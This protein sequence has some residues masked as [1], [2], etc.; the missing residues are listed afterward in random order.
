MKITSEI[1]RHLG[2]APADKKTAPKLHF[3]DYFK[4]GLPTPPASFGHET[5]IGSTGWGMLGNDTLGDCVCAG[6]CHETMLYTAEGSGTAAIFAN[7]QAI[8]LYSAITGY[9]PKKP[10]SDNGTSMSAAAA[11]RHKSGIKDASGAIHKIG[12]YLALTKGNLAEHLC[13][14]YLFGAVGVGIEFPAFA[15]TQFNDGQPW[16]VSKK[17][18]AIEGGHY[19]PLV[20]NRANLEVVTWG[21]LQGMTVAFFEKYNDESIVYLSPEILSG[22]GVTPEGFNLAAL[23]ADLKELTA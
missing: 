4:G 16:D 8:A 22:N 2:K 11:Y 1:V 20:A 14:A 3:K 12:A 23:Q 6:A 7:A 21:R 18:T 15:M 19:I 9:S 13:A 5:F 17:N 10:N